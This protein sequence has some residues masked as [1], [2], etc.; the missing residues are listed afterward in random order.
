M[1]I[2]SAFTYHQR[3]KNI[4]INMSKDPKQITADLARIIRGDVF[5]DI[6]HRFAYSGDASIYS[7]V[8]LCVVAPRDSADIVATIKYAQAEG[9]PVV[10]RGAGSGVAGESLC[11]GIVL[12]TTRYMNKIIRISDDAELVMCEPGVVLDELNNS[13]AKYGRKIGPDPSTSNRAV[14]GGCVANNATGAHS[15]KYGYIGD[16]V[17]SIE[18]VLADGS[19]VQLQDNFDPGNAENEKV[20]SIAKSCAEL[21]SNNEA[22]IAKALPKT[23]RNRSGYTLSLIHI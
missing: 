22:I 19:I 15:L 18:A 20:A 1:K 16:Y 6:L 3:S 13:L 12:D 11:S 10:A 9:I 14:I 8:P 17:E 23:K 2:S 5:G 21:L 4:P 7:I